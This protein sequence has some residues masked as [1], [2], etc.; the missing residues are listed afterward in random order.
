MPRNLLP[1][2]SQNSKMVS[3]ID[4]IF[5]P[6]FKSLLGSRFWDLDLDPKASGALCV[7]VFVFDL[8]CYMTTGVN[9]DFISNCSFTCED[10]ALERDRPYLRKK[11]FSHRK[12]C[13]LPG[14]KKTGAPRRHRIQ[15]VEGPD[16]DPRA[17]ET[18][19]KRGQKVNPLKSKL[20]LP[21]GSLRPS[22]P[23]S[24]LAA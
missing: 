16:L 9:V 13:C 17:E 15:F 23:A 14:L 20:V 21:G 2:G 10:R 8:P 18:Y 5:I 4:H 1:H 24:K 11:R 3:R 19:L 12:F 7:V 22:K 6:S